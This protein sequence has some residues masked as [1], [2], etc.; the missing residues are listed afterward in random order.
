MGRPTAY[1]LLTP[2]LALTACASG[3]DLGAITGDPVPNRAPIAVAGDDVGVAVGDTVALDGGRSRDPDGDALTFR[4]SLVLHPEGTA[5]TLIGADGT[6][7]ALVVDVRGTYV[8]ELIVSD[9]QLQGVPDRVSVRAG[10]DNVAPVADAGPDLEAIVGSE[11]LLDGSASSDANGD[12]LTYAWSAREVPPR[13]PLTQFTTLGQKPLLVMDVAGTYHFELRV[14]DGRLWSEPDELVIEVSAEGPPPTP[15]DLPARALVSDVGRGLLY[16]SVAADSAVPGTA[17][18]VVAIDPVRRE[19]VA[20]L[21]EGGEPGPLALSDDGAS[22][23]VGL[24]TDG[25]VARVDLATGARAEAWPIA[26]REDGGPRVAGQLA[27]VPG[28]PTAVVVSTRLRDQPERFAGLEVLDAR[29][30]RPAV[31]GTDHGL[32]SIVASDAPGR[33]Y[34]VDDRLSAFGVFALDVGPG[35]VTIAASAYH[36]VPGS[37]YEL[38]FDR[39]WLFANSGHAFD[40]ADLT[41]MVTYPLVGPA[42]ADAAQVVFVTAAATRQEAHHLRALARE[43]RLELAAEPLRLSLRQRDGTASHLVRWGARGAAFIHVPDRTS[44]YRPSIVIVESA[45]LAR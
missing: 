1:G 36:G 5:A 18:R 39:G 21:L 15:L 14:S 20:V 35:G 31:I 7:P 4:W 10:I 37:L 28:E 2:L 42:L 23:F 30:P 25:A 9:G 17:D 41:R 26:P 3:D 34:A 8:I 24:R 43:S 38:S 45:L 13:S 27:A 11:V 29:G 22:L 19:T 16:A 40:T 6:K 32:K 12:A 33:L 44:L